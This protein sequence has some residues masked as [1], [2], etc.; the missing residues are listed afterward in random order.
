[1][2]WSYINKT[3]LNLKYIMSLNAGLHCSSSRTS[4]EDDHLV[5]KS[6]VG[7]TVTVCP[8]CDCKSEHEICFY[9][10]KY[11]RYKLKIKKPPKEYESRHCSSTGANHTN[12]LPV[13]SYPPELNE[14]CSVKTEMETLPALVIPGLEYLK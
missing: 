6:S 7:Y 3:E 2:I 9:L 13:P 12:H 1:M 4:A 14:L 11:F 10:S 8:T 5:I